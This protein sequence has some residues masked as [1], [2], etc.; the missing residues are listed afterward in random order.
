ME[1]KIC[2]IRCSLCRTSALRAMTFWLDAME[3][4][5]VS[6]QIYWRFKDKPYMFRSACCDFGS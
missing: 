5:D 4:V 1:P 6:S 3:R 2:K